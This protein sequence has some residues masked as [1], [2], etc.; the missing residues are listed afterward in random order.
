MRWEESQ[1][2][3]RNGKD[4]LI[5]EK[6]KSDTRNGRRIQEE[7]KVEKEEEEEEKEEGD[8]QFVLF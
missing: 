5:Y 8:I 1:C 7:E 6:T 2:I 4:E 3:G